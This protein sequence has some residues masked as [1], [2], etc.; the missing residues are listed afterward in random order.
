MER[1]RSRG[2]KSPPRRVVIVDNWNYEGFVSLRRPLCA[3]FRHTRDKLRALF[4]EIFSSAR[5]PLISLHFIFP[6][7]CPIFFFFFIFNS[8]FSFSTLTTTH[9]SAKFSFV[10][11]PVMEVGDFRLMSDNCV[12]LHF[13]R[14]LISA[15]F[16]VVFIRFRT[17]VVDRASFSGRATRNKEISAQLSIRP[18]PIYSS[19]FVCYHAD[20]A[21]SGTSPRRLPRDSSPLGLTLLP[22]PSVSLLAIQSRCRHKIC[23]RTSRLWTARGAASRRV[24]KGRHLRVILRPL[25]R[26]FHISRSRIRI[27]ELVFRG[28][29]RAGGDPSPPLGSSPTPPCDQRGRYFAPAKKRKVGAEM[30]SP[31][32][33]STLLQ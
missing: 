28:S 26:S 27:A 32:F 15:P 17:V 13:R 4:S 7:F 31:S 9:C 5:S 1:A 22:S 6:P 3:E 21:K 11:A 12:R 8:I 18:A 16:R 29:E 23:G 10:R 2:W 20:R 24:Y 30:R 19:I 33:R 25:K 14:E